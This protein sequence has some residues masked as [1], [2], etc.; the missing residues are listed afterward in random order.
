MDSW[1]DSRLDVEAYQD[2]RY[3]NAGTQKVFCWLGSAW[4][5]CVVW[6]HWWH[7]LGFC[8]Y[9]Q[10]WLTTNSWLCSCTCWLLRGHFD[11][12]LLNHDVDKKGSFSDDGWVEP[13]CHP[14]VFLVLSLPLHHSLQSSS[15]LGFISFNTAQ[16]ASSFSHR[17]HINHFPIIMQAYQNKTRWIKLDTKINIQHS[18]I[19]KCRDVSND[20]NLKV[21]TYCRNANG[22]NQKK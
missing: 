5:A 18:N 1:R 7:F 3:N 8:S 13:L 22:T 4:H 16:A 20:R 11:F 21:Y 10:S 19:N 9:I 14:H 2:S 6:G 17:L 12:P 15:H